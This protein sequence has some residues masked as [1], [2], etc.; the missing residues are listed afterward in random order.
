MRSRLALAWLGN[1]IWVV[2]QR[3]LGGGGGDTIWAGLGL[4]GRSKLGIGLLVELRLV[5]LA[6]LGGRSLA[7]DYGW[8]WGWWVGWSWNE[9]GKDILW[10]NWIL[11]S[12]WLYFQVVPNMDPGVKRFLISV[13]HWNKCSPSL[14]LQL[15]YSDGD[16]AFG[17][18]LELCI[19]ER[20]NCIRWHYSGQV[21]LLDLAVQFNIIVIYTMASL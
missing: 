11:F 20:Q 12:V 5:G 4:A 18:S 16:K 10:S 15:M 2:G 21:V 7:S 19:D 6:W 13:Y 8:S 1:A 14:V 9:V 3:D 17:T